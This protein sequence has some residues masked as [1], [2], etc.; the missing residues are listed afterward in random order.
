MGLHME[1][2][3]LTRKIR[4]PNWETLRQ[5]ENSLIFRALPIA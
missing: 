3:Q 5:I 1:G 2:L 4:L